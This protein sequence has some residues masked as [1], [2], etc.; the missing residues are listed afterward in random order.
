MCVADGA[1]EARCIQQQD[2]ARKHERVT[3]R[4]N[5][6]NTSRFSRLLKR[7]QLNTKASYK[8]CTVGGK[9]IKYN[10]NAYERDTLHSILR[11]ECNNT[12]NR[13]GSIG[14]AVLHMACWGRCGTPTFLSVSTSNL[15]QKDRWLKYIK[16][17]LKMMPCG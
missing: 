3:E 12:I 7:A 10:G 5:T 4:E 6:N 15:S 1:A 13:I 8:V 9:Q 16:K 17:T 14:G 2:K 11:G